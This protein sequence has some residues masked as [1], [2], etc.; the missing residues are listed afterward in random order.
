MR[1]AKCEKIKVLS[2]CPAYNGTKLSN[3][4]NNELASRSKAR[5][6][7]DQLPFCL[8]LNYIAVRIV[9]HANTISL[10]GLDTCKLKVLSR[11]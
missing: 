9:Q 6:R 10:A 3:E 8:L 4:L 5:T 2:K 11:H 1:E 7:Q